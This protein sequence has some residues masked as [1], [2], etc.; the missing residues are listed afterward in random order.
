MINTSGTAICPYCR[1]DSIIGES[2]KYPITKEFLKM[3]KE[4]WF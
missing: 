1:V 4:Y 2:S 3:M